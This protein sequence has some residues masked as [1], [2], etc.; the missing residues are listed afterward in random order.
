M[1]AETHTAGATAAEP[2]DTMLD[3]PLVCHRFERGE[4][5]WY[6]AWTLYLKEVLRFLKVPTQTVFA[7][8]VTALLM[9]TIFSLALGRALREMGGV[10]F[11]EF[12][13][14]GLIMMAMIQSAFSHT[15]SSLVIAKLQGNIVDVLMPPLSPGELV[16]GYVMAAATRGVL[17]GLITTLGMWAFVPI[18]VHDIGFIAF[19]A[20][21]TSLLLALLGLIGGIWADKFDHMAA[22]TNFVITP[23]AF[24]SGTFYSV[25]RLPE[26]WY[27]VSQFNPF[28]YMIDGFR[29][30]FIGH[31]DGSLTAG[32][33]VMIV[34]N[35]VLWA[36]VHMMIASGY[37]VKP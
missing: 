3:R 24:L 33:W 11:L 29:Y 34:G 16:F 7:P 4:I 17:V 31:A 26:P 25:G 32:I 21:S 6:G 5:N 28:F 15:S 30:A 10:P 23:L 14:P 37:R 22:I 2:I 8:M 27:T 36:A 19:H 12:L 13:A 18:R 9:L 1:V 35:I 20:V